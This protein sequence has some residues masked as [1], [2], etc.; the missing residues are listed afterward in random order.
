MTKQQERV[1]KMP[2]TQTLFAMMIKYK[3][4]VTYLLAGIGLV[5]IFFIGRA[6]VDIPEKEII[7]KNEIAVKDKLFKQLSQSQDECVLRLNTQRDVSDNECLAKKAIWIK[8]YKT[9]SS[10]VD[11][12]TAKALYKQ[13][14]NKDKDFLDRAIK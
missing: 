13:C 1:I 7:C 10:L 9:E 8:K 11:C 4:Q 5:S 2:D 12:E 3:D 6:T 14:R